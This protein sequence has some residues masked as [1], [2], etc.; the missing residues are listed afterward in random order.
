M[1]DVLDRVREKPR[2]QRQAI[3][4]SVAAVVTGVVFILW[5]VSF[6]ASIQGEQKI[7]APS[8][9]TFGFDTFVDSF[10]EASNAI[11]Q[12]VGTAREQLELINN[13]LQKTEQEGGVGAE[14]NIVE[15]SSPPTV[16]EAEITPS[17]IEIIQIGG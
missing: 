7:T 5:I 15:E 12:E 17:G 8:E 3:A 13:E 2:A 6:F 9:S 4:L 16:Q 11:K 1:F 14:E 10:Q